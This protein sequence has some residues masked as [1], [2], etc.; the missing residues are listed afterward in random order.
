MKPHRIPMLWWALPA[1]LAAGASAQVNQFIALDTAPT[2][3]SIFINV[4]ME[5]DVAYVTWGDVLGGTGTPATLALYD[6]SDPSNIVALDTETW[7]SPHTAGDFV[8]SNRMVYVC[9]FVGNR[10]RIFDATD[11]SAI[12]AKGVSGS[13]FQPNAIALNAAAETLFVGYGQGGGTVASFDV[14]NPDSFLLLN[15]T[16]SNAAGPISMRY[17]GGVLHVL[18]SAGVLATFDVSNPSSISFLGST[19]TNLS[20]P[21]EM[22]LAGDRVYTTDTGS[23]R[24]GIYDVSTPSVPA[25]LGGRTFPSPRNVVVENGI[26]YVLDASTSPN[27]LYAINV[28]NPAATVELASTTTNVLN[29][30]NVAVRNG[31]VA[32]TNL[33]GDTLALFRASFVGSGTI[34]SGIVYEDLDADG[35]FDFLDGEQGF[36]DVT[37]NLVRDDDFDG[38]VDP[39]ETV[40][41]T[42]TTQVPGG[43]QFGDV[44]AGTYLLQVVDTNNVLVG[45]DL[46]SGANPASQSVMPNS[47]IDGVNFGYRQPLPATPSP[48]PSPSPSP[49][50]SPSDSPT[51]S[52]TDS[53]T[54]SLTPSETPSPTPSPSDSPTP[55]PTDSPTPSLTPSE[56][57]SPTPSPSDSPTPSPTDSPTPSL[58]PS[59]T[60]SPTPSPTD[61]PTPSLTPSETPSPTPSPSDSPTPSPTDSPTP[62]LTPSETPSP[63]PTASPTP[64]PTVTLSPTPMAHSAWRLY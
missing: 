59:E 28:T 20:S 40:V 24:L 8:V 52:P 33:S 19:S 41:A 53:P 60:P 64:P 39:G 34:I 36:G 18:R 46:V 15:S 37:V 56:T 57:P 35:V 21:I 51:P 62:S 1:M 47:V 12:V 25:Y 48:S 27:R 44:P 61:S 63:T 31:L 54:P 6:I 30:W 49:T 42:T 45:L 29:P 4:K 43:Y 9:D 16:T 23:D 7:G 10:V 13:I 26:A 50:P 5:E 17:G 38:L 14:S 58:T 2:S 32:I 3:G 55:S 11:P 22:D